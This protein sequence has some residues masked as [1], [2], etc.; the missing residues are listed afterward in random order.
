MP[1]GQG[2]PTTVVMLFSS[3]CVSI[4]LPA[5]F[6][7]FFFLT[8]TTAITNTG[9]DEGPVNLGNEFVFVG[10]TRRAFFWRVGVLLRSVFKELTQMFA[11]YV[12]PENNSFQAEL[13]YPHYLT[14]P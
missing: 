1:K 7:L 10:T 9:R 6:F 2:A 8:D 14:L 5:F 13:L 4:R 12:Q 11:V 3:P